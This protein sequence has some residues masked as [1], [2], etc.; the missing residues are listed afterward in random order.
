MR[1]RRCLWP[2]TEKKYDWVVNERANGM[3][4]STVRVLQESKRIA[5]E[6]NI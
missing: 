3:S 2:T 4:I 1:F 6:D 5:Q